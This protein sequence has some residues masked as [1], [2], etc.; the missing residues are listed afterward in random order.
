[1][2]RSVINFMF[3]F[4]DDFYTAYTSGKITFDLMFPE[5]YH[6]PAHAS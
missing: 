1:M 4:Q 3:L 2:Y 6:G 5:A